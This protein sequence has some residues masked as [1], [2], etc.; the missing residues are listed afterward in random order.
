MLVFYKNNTFILKNDHNSFKKLIN[1]RPLSLYYTKFRNNQCLNYF[2]TVC[3]KFFI[4]LKVS[5]PTELYFCDK[6]T[7]N[8]CNFDTLNFSIKKKKLFSGYSHIVS[9]P[10]SSTMLSY[11]SV[12]FS[13]KI[14]IIGT[15]KFYS[16]VAVN[17]MYYFFK[18]NKYKLKGMR[19]KFEIVKLKPGK[20][21][22]N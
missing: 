19:G 10:L 18:L 6:S 3:S 1:I 8:G 9:L 13:N 22:N 14:T 21:L 17:S 5:K 11:F 4:F 16:N 7:K 12:N 2:L 15:S 20:S